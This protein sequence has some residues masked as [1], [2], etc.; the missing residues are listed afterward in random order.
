[1]SPEELRAFRESLGLSRREFA[2]K[3]FISEPTLERWE[4]GQGGPREPHVQMLRRM[5]EHVKSGQSLAYFRYDSGA[6]PADGPPDDRQTISGTLKAL[7]AL[8]CGERGSRD[9][10]TWTLLFSPDWPARE[11]ARVSLAVMSSFLPQRPTIDFMLSVECDLSPLDGIHR[12]INTICADHGMAWQPTGRWENPSGLALYHRIFNTACDSETVQHV[13]GNLRSC[14]GRICKDV[15]SREDPGQS[16]RGTRKT[17]TAARSGKAEANERPADTGV[18]RR[19]DERRL[20]VPGRRAWRPRDRDQRQCHSQQ[21]AALLCRRPF[22]LLR[23][24]ARERVG[25]GAR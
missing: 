25:A 14:W 21:A 22:R 10:R 3:L 9:G 15:L 8:P 6:E 17:L 24:S 7:G 13:Y 2:P 16:P 19:H 12:N 11:A 5:R 4:R 18:D 1:M 20:S 23:R